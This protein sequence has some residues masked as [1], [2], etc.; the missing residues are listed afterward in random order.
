MHAIYIAAVHIDHLHAT[1]GSDSAINLISHHSSVTTNITDWGAPVILD[2]APNNKQKHS[3]GQCSCQS[4]YRQEL[5]RH[6]SLST[7]R[8]IDGKCG[9]YYTQA[10][11]GRGLGRANANIMLSLEDP[12]PGTCGRAR[13][14]AHLIDRI[15]VSAIARPP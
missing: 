7:R 2:R 5:C 8:P 12:S 13:A 10:R 14:K 4:N 11:W 15:R 9:N 1:A 3:H 6:L